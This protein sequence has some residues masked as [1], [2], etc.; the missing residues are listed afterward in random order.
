MYEETKAANQPRILVIRS[1]PRN[2]YA[3]RGCLLEVTG[4]N[5]LESIDT[6][7]SLRVESADGK[8]ILSK[9]LESNWETG[10]SQLYSERLET[11][12]LSGKYIVRIVASAKDGSIVAQNSRNFHIF[13]DRESADISQP[14]ALLDG[15]GVLTRHLRA[16][17]I[18]FTDFSAQT[19]RQT[20]VF[21]GRGVLDNPDERERREDLVRHIAGG[22]TVVYLTDTVRHLQQGTAPRTSEDQASYS[23]PAQ[24]ALDL[25]PAY[26]S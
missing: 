5:E 25:Y 4:V 9:K 13:S 8:Q 14:I 26:R 15:D 12:T 17:Y 11:Q 24:G 10:V 16:K 19:L 21:V 23:F 18:L 20:P 1:L 22:G 7:M 2:V 6:D 3:D